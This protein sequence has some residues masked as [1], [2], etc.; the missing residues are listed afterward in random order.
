VSSNFVMSDR[1]DPARECAWARSIRGLDVLSGFPRPD[2]PG[3]Q[4][5][6]RC[7]QK[8]PYAWTPNDPIKC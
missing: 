4:M 7:I 6:S 2:R 1:R 5:R 8:E 3:I